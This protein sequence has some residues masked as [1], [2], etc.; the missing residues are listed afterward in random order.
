[1][2]FSGNM[3]WKT[4]KIKKNLKKAHLIQ[5]KGIHRHCIE[6]FRSFSSCCKIKIHIKTKNSFEMSKDCVRQPA[7][8]TK[9]I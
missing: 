2:H 4:L 9:V 7:V 3:D 8:T 1:M 6:N 5:K